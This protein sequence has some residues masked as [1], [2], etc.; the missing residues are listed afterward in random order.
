[1]GSGMFKTVVQSSAAKGSL[2]FVD[3]LKHVRYRLPTPERQEN[4]RP[5]D[6]H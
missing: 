4:H 2:A 6:S 5:E 3:E 1:M